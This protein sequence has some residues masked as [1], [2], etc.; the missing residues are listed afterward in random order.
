MTNR[1]AASCSDAASSAS[2]SLRTSGISCNYF[3][4]NN[5][6]KSHV[7]DNDQLP[8]SL[9]LLVKLLADNL[10]ARKKILI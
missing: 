1:I 8:L 9:L 7:D 2:P 10:N 6:V 3:M 4:I 5:L